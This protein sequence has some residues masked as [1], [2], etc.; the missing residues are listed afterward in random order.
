MTLTGQDEKYQIAVEDT[1]MIFDENRSLPSG[2]Y[3]ILDPNH[4]KLICKLAPSYLIK[5]KALITIKAPV[6]VIGD[7]HAQYTYLWKFLKDYEKGGKYLFLGDYV[8]RGTNSLECIT[9]LL[10]L[11]MLYPKQ[12]YLIRGNH[13][14][15]VMTQ[16]YGFHDECIQRFGEEEGEEIYQCFL[17]VFDNLP[18]AAVISSDEVKDKKIF[19]V[20]GGLAPTLKGLKQIRDLSFPIEIPEEGIDPKVAFVRDILWSDPSEE[21]EGYSANSQRNGAF[22]YGI[23]ECKK[24]ME[25]NKLTSIF[26]AH[27]VVMGGYEYPFLKKYDDTSV[28]TIFSSPNYCDELR[29][30]GA[31]V[32]VK[33][34]MEI[35]IE[36][37]STSL[38]T[39]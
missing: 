36:T 25:A 27:Q 26:R 17:K 22:M 31:I 11:K 18:I 34:D 30:S 2:Q 21:D 6:Y 7:I 35:S 14:S 28:L 10:C 29:N 33:R 1:F 15:E 19:C 38:F 39:I 3:L 12:F 32:T 8:D 16:T 13:E 24:F 23:N 9:L 4:I 5:D 20:H 37:V